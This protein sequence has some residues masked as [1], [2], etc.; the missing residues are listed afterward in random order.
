MNIKAGPA[1]APRRL[2]CK[3]LLSALF[4]AWAP[5]PEAAAQTAGVTISTTTIGMREGAPISSDFYTVVLDTNPGTT[6]TITVTSTDANAIK[7]DAGS[8]AWKASDILTF[9]S[10]DWSTAKTVKVYGEQ[11][12][13]NQGEEEIEITHAATATD[14]NSP[15]HQIQIASVQGYVDD[16]EGDILIRPVSC[17]EGETIVGGGVSGGSISLNENPTGTVTV[18]LSSSDTNLFTVS[19]P[20]LTY[21]ANELGPK[22][23]TVTCGDD[24]VF[25]P[26]R[27]RTGTLTA[28]ASGANYNGV[29]KTSDVQVF[30]D[31]R[32]PV[33]LSIANNGS[34]SEGTTG[35]TVTI[36]ATAAIPIDP[37]FGTI[38]IQLDRVEEETTAQR[39]I[40][41]SLEPYSFIALTP[42]NAAG[43]ITLRVVS[44]AADEPDERLRLK[45]R[46]PL[47]ADHTAG[48]TKHVDIRIADG[49]PTSVT[50]SA[51]AS[52]IDESGNDSMIDVTITLGREL[53]ANES[54]TV[55]LNVTGATVATHYTL[56]LKSGGNLNAGVTISTANPHSAQNPSVT[57]AGAGARTAT[58]E[59]AAV[60]NSDATART[61]SIAFGAGAR[62]P[63]ETGLN[64]GITL[65]GS[66]ATI[67][68]VD[69]D[70]TAT[71]VA[72]FASASASAAESAGTQNA[73]INFSPAPSAA[74][75]VN[76][77]LSGAATLGADYTISGVTSSNGTVSVNGGDTSVN[78]P[79]AITD[80]SADEPNE[81]LILTLTN[82]TGYDVGGANA[83]TLT[84]AD[85]DDDGGGTGGGG[86]GGG[87]GGGDDPSE[88]T[89][90]VAPNPVVEGEEITVTVSLSRLVASAVTI[91][92]VL[93]AETAEA[94]DYGALASIVVEANQPSGTGAITTTKDDDKD[95]ETFTVAL[96]T[97]PS[98]L[99]AGAPASAQVTITNAI[100]TSIESPADEIPTAFALEQNYPNPFNP[101]TTIAFALDKTQHVTLSVYDLLGQEVQ[102]LVDG[103]RPAA[104][105]RIPFDAT[106]L[107]SGTY[108]YV[109]RT[110]E[111][112][113]VK[114]MALLK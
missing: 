95:D 21:M 42:G 67:D 105:Y 4:L 13:D 36:T 92:L 54:V 28:T 77:S 19:P 40:D 74:I 32:I 63:S 43:S 93:T 104:R 109:L 82:G 25:T 107:A 7:V 45:I 71:P 81:T 9:G 94:E 55:P 15:Y 84:I 38:N 65:W 91:P 53:V 47:A 76:Y 70:G 106:D 101:T 27:S 78:I 73:T 17:R 114:T 5:V 3:T 62:A 90:S 88:V 56:G 34:V 37:V 6:V 50:L 10:S 112:V 96:G 111:Q 64:G 60:D 48:A 52:N 29:S 87:T 12:S 8:G 75:T 2:L 18:S 59:L 31:E 30:D 108:L 1:L 69:D 41:Y 113:A 44:D 85:N 99:E 14:A 66:P 68:I 103:V 110:E 49:D 23:Y 57:L 11:D 35:N 102:V 83:H 86:G 39:D 20:S 51:G 22:P 61:V 72:N 97:L 89:L 26:A 24:N 58:L 33:N 79:V 80:D 98:G 46:E 100:V 16:D